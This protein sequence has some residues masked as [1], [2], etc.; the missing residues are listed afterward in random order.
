MGLGK[1]AHAK[2]AVAHRAEGILHTTSDLR[3]AAGKLLQAQVV[4]NVLT[5]TAF[6]L[7]RISPHIYRL[8]LSAYKHVSLDNSCLS[9]LK[10]CTCDACVCV[11]ARVRASPSMGIRS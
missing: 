10:M 3:P 9:L 7:V 6:L 5:Q 8:H 2:L 4:E 1:H 11:R